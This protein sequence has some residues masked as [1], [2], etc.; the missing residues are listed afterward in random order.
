M[1]VYMKYRA[2]DCQHNAWSQFTPKSGGEVER[3]TLVPAPIVAFS[4]LAH[5]YN[6]AIVFN[7]K[8]L[9]Y[10]RG[11]SYAPSAQTLC[12]AAAPIRCA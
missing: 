7:T 2:P 6:N 9:R 8:K 10:T 5:E 4:G 12:W 3:L 1:G 11:R